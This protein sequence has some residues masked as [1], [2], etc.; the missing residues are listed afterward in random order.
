VPSLNQRVVTGLAEHPAVVAWRDVC[1]GGVVPP[2][3]QVVKRHAS[4]TIYRLEDAGRYGEPVMA[5]RCVSTTAE[6]EHIIYTDVLPALPVS[7]PRYYGKVQGRKHGFTWLFLQDV[8]NEEFTPT[9][10][11]HR[12]LAATWLGQLHAGAE[13]LPVTRRMPD[14]GPNHYLEHLRRGR[15]TIKRHLGNPALSGEDQALLKA[16]IELFDGLEE[17]WGDVE[18]LCAGMPQT[19][20]HG[21][22]RAGNAR[23]GATD[24]GRALLPFDWETAGWGI[25]AADLAPARTMPPPEL[26]DLSGYASVVRDQ[27]PWLDRA[28]LQDLVKTGI[29]FRRLAAI[30]WGS[31]SLQFRWVE[32]PVASMQLYFDHLSETLRSAPWR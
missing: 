7:S 13:H 17:D 19:V 27:W 16:V 12:S 30:S 14:R 23:V 31:L 21:D 22:F 25:P 24:T 2:S 9:S 8:G 18:R 28:A 20:V 32:K 5:K 3:L 11:E 6:T 1:P 29:V 4:S 15:S 10:P 26:V